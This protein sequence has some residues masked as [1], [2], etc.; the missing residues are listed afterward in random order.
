MGC[1]VQTTILR[2]CALR[3]LCHVHV[4]I[5]LDDAGGQEA[6]QPVEAML[7]VASYPAN[8]IAEM[9]YTFWYRLSRT[10]TTSF[11]SE[12][13]PSLQACAHLWFHLILHVRC[14]RVPALLIYKMMVQKLH[15]AIIS[16]A[17]CADLRLYA[18]HQYPS[19]L[20]SE[21]CVKLQAMIP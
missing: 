1:T 19:N 9:S 3:G 20:L 21:L 5:F 13:A 16:A 7:A 17:G 2:C 10:L 11:G 4:V 12:R 18:L 8:A 6:L 14:I 15:Q